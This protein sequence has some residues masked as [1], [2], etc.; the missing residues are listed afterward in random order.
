V[1]TVADVP[2][3]RATLRILREERARTQELLDRLSRR[4]L[5]APGLGGGQW[6]PKDLIGH[7]AS[8]EEYALDALD[9]W[10]RGERA[11]ID[12]LWSIGT[13]AI[14]RQNVERKAAWPLARVRRESERTFAELL[15]A[16]ASLTDARWRGPV[17]SRGRR[18]LGARLGSILGGPAGPFRH[19]TS[20]Q[21]SLRSFAG[22]EVEPPLSPGAR[23]R[24]SATSSR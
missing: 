19:D 21:P 4:R 15:D 17:S 12:L 18:P 24:R 23:R 1:S 22:P 3:R 20:H 6:S 11:P 2:T 10:D 8:W 7:L 13:N 5:T 16:I 14:N 9:A